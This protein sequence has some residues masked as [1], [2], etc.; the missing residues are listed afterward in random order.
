MS[1]EKKEKG[2]ARPPDAP[3]SVG[4]LVGLGVGL[5]VGLAAATCGLVA[6]VPAPDL[7][8]RALCIGVGFRIV[9]GWGGAAF[10]RSMLRKPA[11]TPGITG[12]K[13]EGDR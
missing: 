7:L 4:R 12:H 6:G 13:P 3:R 11:A 8:L 10:A 5:T 1:K 9:A 2:P